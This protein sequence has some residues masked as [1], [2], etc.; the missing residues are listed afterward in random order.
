[1][2]LLELQ[3]I[4]TSLGVI[5]MPMMI[6]GATR[7]CK[8]GNLVPKYAVLIAAGVLLEAHSGAKVIIALPPSAVRCVYAGFLL[9]MGVRMLVAGK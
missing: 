8:A 9:V 2:K 7:H 4:G 5:V 3:A 1:M 6:L